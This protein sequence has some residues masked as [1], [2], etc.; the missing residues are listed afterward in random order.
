MTKLS[1]EFDFT[2]ALKK[3]AFW[4][5]FTAN[6]RV[7]QRPDYRIM[8][9]AKGTYYQTVEGKQLFDTLSGLWCTPLGHGN[10][11]I[12]EALKTQAE[13]L[14]FSPAFQLANP[15]TLRL[16]ER[17]AN[18]A[19]D[20]MNHVFFGNSGSEA[21][22]TALKIALGFHRLR[23]EGGRFRMIGRERGYHGVGFGGMSV[24]G[25]VP[26]RKMFAAGMMNGVDHLRHTWDPSVMAFSKGQPEWGA[27]RADDLERLVGLHD[28]S[29][30]AAV[31]VE[32]VQGSTG[33]LVP[34]VGY[35]QRLREICTKYGILLIFDEV[36]TG[37]GRMGHGFAAQR[38]G[39]K[40]DMI[41]FAKAVTNGIVPM[42]GV[43]V[44]DEIYNT[45][46]T[47]PEN[48][49]E[50]AHGYTYS[51]HPL[52]AAVGHVVLDI[53]EEE[54][55]FS[56]VLG[57]EPVLEEAIHTLDEI[58]SVSDVRNIGLTAAVD[59]KPS[60][61]GVG[62]RGLEIFERGLEAGLLLRCTGDTISFGPPFI[63]T[64]EQL[65][66]MVG[67]VRELVIATA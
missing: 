35:L 65:R 8:A 49:I 54:N 55:L 63:S 2:D 1:N 16:A 21:V 29:T 39:V 51:G 27:E 32:P 18:M 61:E 12:A 36:I 31:I 50:F 52:A 66:D 64:P 24:G 23:K 22:D 48:A 42:G 56:K 43:I 46:M 28:A 25:I 53:M 15:V 60:A 10:P 26:N 4:M 5:P 20:G 33:V 7:K 9:S 3:G 30:I 11:R 38:F 59:L 34:P 45:F 41:T 57:L 67:V 6:R 13:T 17:I 14:D 62:V 40:P 58:D 19:P 47:G 37:F 44:T